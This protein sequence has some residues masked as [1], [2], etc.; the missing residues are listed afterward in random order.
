MSQELMLKETDMFTPEKTQLIKDSFFKD[1]SDEEF[2]LFMQVCKHTQL[3][4]VFKQIYPVKRWD[5]KLRR[6]TVTYQTSIDGY[7]LIAERTGCYVP[8]PKPVW[9]YDDKGNLISA[10]ASVKK[11]ARDGSWHIIEAEAFYDE[12]CQKTKENKPTAMWVNMKRSQLAKCAESLALRK[13]FP[14]ELSGVYTKDEM[15]QAEIIDIR[16]EPK[17]VKKVSKE[18][19]EVIEAI[20]FDAPDYKQV[21]MSHLA[22]APYNVKSIYDIP[23]DFY[24]RIVNGSSKQ[25]Q[26]AQISQVQPSEIPIPEVYESVVN[27]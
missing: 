4:P 12:Y 19:A 18:Q 2:M 3:D 22:N 20:F 5:S 13:A 14:A 15:Q 8:G 9:T 24:E 25:K 17:P 23:Q 21:V 11:L 27:G 6:E 10:I 16:P 1:S 7:R 26:G